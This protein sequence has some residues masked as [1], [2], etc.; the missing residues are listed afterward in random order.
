MMVEADENAIEFR[1][2]H[3][4][5]CSRQCRERFLASPGLFVGQG[6]HKAPAQKGRRVIKQR[7][8]KPGRPP[9]AEMAA[10][11]FDTVQAMTGIEDMAIEGDSVTLRY[12]LLQAAEAQIEVTMAQAGAVPGH[13]GS[14][15]LR[16]AFV[17]YLEETELD[18]LAASTSSRG[19]CH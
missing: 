7:R 9:A 5:L 10:K 1:Q 8:L 15:R 19:H 14:Q 11:A 6:S 4:L 2:M 3:F 12:D 16:R 13:E 17:R 18:S